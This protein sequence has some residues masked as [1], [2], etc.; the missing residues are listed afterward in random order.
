MAG[1]RH[2]TM[3]QNPMALGV[4]IWYSATKPHLWIHSLG[5]YREVVSN[6]ATLHHSNGFL[7]LFIKNLYEFFT[8][9]RLLSIYWPLGMESIYF[10]RS[11]D[12]NSKTRY[13]LF[14]CIRT[15]SRLK[16]KHYNIFF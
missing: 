6:H 14:S 12:R 4:T 11:I 8:L 16:E 3:H 13:N 7:P 9:T 15:S 10:F 1:F 5:K 2:C